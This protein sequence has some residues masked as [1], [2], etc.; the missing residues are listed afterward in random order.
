M[1]FW[2]IVS[3]F[4]PLRQNRWYISFGDDEFQ[5]ALKECSK[6]EYEVSFT[7]HRLL[8]QTFKYPGLLKWKP[9]TIKLA[10]TISEKFTLDNFMEKISR[11]SGYRSPRDF[12]YKVETVQDTFNVK[13]EGIVAPEPNGKTKFYEKKSFNYEKITATETN[14]NHQQISKGTAEKL[15]GVDSFGD[16]LV[17]FSII[18]INQNGDFVE[19]WDL[20]NCFI[21]SVNYGTLTYGGE[22]IVEISLTVQYDWATQN[23]ENFYNKIE[24]NKA[25]A[26][27]K[28]RLRKEAE[29]AA[30]KKA[31]EAKKEAE[32]L[33]RQKLKEDADIA[34]YRYNRGEI[35]EEERNRA[36][37]AVYADELKENRAVIAEMNLQYK[38][39]KAAAE[40]QAQAKEREQAI[41]VQQLAAEAEEK[42]REETLAAA[43]SEAQKEK[44]ESSATAT[45]TSETLSPKPA[46]SN[47]TADEQK[48]TDAT[49]TSETPSTKPAVNNI[50]AEEQRAIDAAVADARTATEKFASTG[51][52]YNE[53]VKTNTRVAVLTNLASRTEENDIPGA[54]SRLPSVTKGT[55]S[56]TN[57]QKS[58]TSGL[59]TAPLVVPEQTSEAQ[60]IISSPPAKFKKP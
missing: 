12:T 16:S 55:Q 51:E 58:D 48:A 27:E 30:A 18:Q 49:A 21:S 17:K 41:V 10:S 9:V 60:K 6:P 7:E 5:W 26:K 42:K 20:Y 22:E 38:Q 1:A 36:I 19:S 33:R 3:N 47:N 39:E 35:T 34:V 24:Q 23:E 25:I 40:A 14:G 37:N 46:V 28:E 43:R 54:T 4:E 52:G 2:S 11:A 32:R 56:S 44:D 31:E 57:I 29:A 59:L 45:A 15:D 53:A 8:T 13:K 50:T